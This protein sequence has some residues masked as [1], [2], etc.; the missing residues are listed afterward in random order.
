MCELGSQESETK[1]KKLR[2]IREHKHMSQILVPVHPYSN[3]SIFQRVH[4][5]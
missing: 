5:L 3:I 4:E 1:D 2:T